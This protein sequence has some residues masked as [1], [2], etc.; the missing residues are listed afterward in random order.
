M[1]VV[2]SSKVT[3]VVARLGSGWAL[4]SSLPQ[5]HGSDWS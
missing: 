4:A 3:L 5:Q 2:T 1:G